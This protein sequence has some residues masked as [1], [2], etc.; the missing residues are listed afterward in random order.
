MPAKVRLISNCSIRQF[1]ID[2]A[3]VIDEFSCLGYEIEVLFSSSL[4]KPDSYSVLVYS[5][6]VLGWEP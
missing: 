3:S 4:D 1:E 5:A 2:L 6:L